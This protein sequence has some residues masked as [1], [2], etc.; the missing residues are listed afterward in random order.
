MTGIRVLEYLGQNAEGDIPIKPSAMGNCPFA[1]R[2]CKKLESKDKKKPV[3]SVRDNKGKMYIVCSERLCSSYGKKLTEHQRDILYQTAKAVFDDIKYVDVG[4]RT[5]VSFKLGKR[6]RLHAD[7]VLVD[8]STPTRSKP[9]RIVVEFQGG[10]ET[11][12]TGTMT[13]FVDKWENDLN[14]TNATLRQRLDK[15]APIVNNAWKRQLDQLII[16]G[17]IASRTGYKFAL[18]VG[19]YFADYIYK[20]IDR[21]ND[22]RDGGW[23]LAILP[24]SEIKHESSQIKFE[25]NKKYAFYTTVEDF[26]SNL[27]SQGS[28]QKDPFDGVFTK[29]N[30][31]PVVYPNVLGG[32]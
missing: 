1:D 10:G 14:R 3:C 28:M 8:M 15:G 5:E 22:L 27:S 2:T 11:S 4:Y 25:L 21:A 16:E 26:I 7:F 9:P 29:L 24:F 6:R 20:R 12:D 23:N 18:C 30:G 19:E 32:A 13:N 31:E 17:S